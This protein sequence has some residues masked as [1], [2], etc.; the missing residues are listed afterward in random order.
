VVLHAAMEVWRVVIMACRRQIASGSRLSRN[1]RVAL[2][3]AASTSTVVHVVVHATPQ[4]R[5]YTNQ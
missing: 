5:N 1:K 2:V 3:L 4:L